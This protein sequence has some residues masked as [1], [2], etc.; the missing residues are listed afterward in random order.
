MPPSPKIKEH[1]QVAAFDDIISSKD[2]NSHESRVVKN[3]R[4]ILDLLE[5][6]TQ[7]QL[8]SSSAGQQKET[9]TF[10]FPCAAWVQ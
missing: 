5:N 6:T 2:W 7:K 8:F 9:P 4:V 3:T 10:W 1:F